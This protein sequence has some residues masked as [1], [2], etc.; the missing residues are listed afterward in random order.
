MCVCVSEEGEKWH[1][2]FNYC[3]PGTVPGLLQMLSH[4]ILK[5][6]DKVGT[7]INMLLVPRQKVKRLELT[8]LMHHV[9]PTNSG[10]TTHLFSHFTESLAKQR[11][12]FCRI[13]VSCSPQVPV[14]TGFG[15]PCFPSIGIPT[16]APR[17]PSV[18]R[19][20]GRTCPGQCETAPDTR[21][22]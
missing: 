9:S 15:P 3:K 21:D 12:G 2:L 18:G 11:T 20:G 5:W 16:L 22:G 4:L 14:V 1:L 19:G 8:K 6:L 10:S 7:S 13:N 17:L